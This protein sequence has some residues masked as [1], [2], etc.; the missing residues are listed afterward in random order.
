MIS[1]AGGKSLSYGLEAWMMCQ[2]SKTTLMVTAIRTP[3]QRHL[4][5]RVDVVLE[6][7]IPQ[8]LLPPYTSPGADSNTEGVGPGNAQNLFQRNNRT[9]H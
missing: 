4:N 3:G 1:E 7:V 9:G 5:F 6:L 8:C 2:P